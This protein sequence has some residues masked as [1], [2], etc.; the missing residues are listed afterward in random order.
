[1]RPMYYRMDGTPYTGPNALFEWSKDFE[2]TEARRIGFDKLP[3]GLEIS[4]VWLGFDHSIF[5][6]RPLIFETMVFAP[7]PEWG[8]T[9]F[10]MTRYSTLEEAR[11]GHKMFVKK[12]QTFKNAEDVL[13]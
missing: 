1:M 11:F 10:D 7:D 13:A 2:N 9:K 8:M 3:N 12:Y 5:G 4:T 6:K